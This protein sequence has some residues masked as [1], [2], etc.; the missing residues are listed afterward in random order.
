MAEIKTDD[1]KRK[2]YRGIIKQLKS[3]ADSEGTTQKYTYNGV[4][5]IV[6]PDS[7]IKDITLEYFKELY[8]PRTC[9]VCGKEFKP[10]K[11]MI[12]KNYCSIK[13]STAGRIKNNNDPGIQRRKRIEKFVNS[14]VTL[15]ILAIAEGTFKTSTENRKGKN[16]NRK[17]VNAK[18]VS[19][20]RSPLTKYY[21]VNTENKAKKT[22]IEGFLEELPDL[23]IRDV[24]TLRSGGTHD[25]GIYI[26]MKMKSD[27]ED[28]G[29]YYVI[30]TEE[31]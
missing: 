14:L 1:G 25:T 10:T 31:E 11:D 24:P 27:I 12:S 28:A 18:G 19:K 2:T 26:S 7:S 13:C 9:P 23:Q 4:D 21:I 6:D 8:K 3:L 22:D 20:Y 17:Y 16:V 29:Y 5:I 15:D 30:V